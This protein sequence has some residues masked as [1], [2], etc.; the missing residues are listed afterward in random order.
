MKA[1]ADYIM[2][3]TPM[4]PEEMKALRDRMAAEH[5]ITVFTCDECGAAARCELSFDPYNTN[6]D[7]LAEK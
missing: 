1:T 5:D 7:C 2:R 3:Q 6:G 4:T